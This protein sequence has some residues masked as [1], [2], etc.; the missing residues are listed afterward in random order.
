MSY[1]VETGQM[2]YYIHGDLGLAV[3]SALGIE[4]LPTEGIAFLE[5]I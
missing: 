1:A 3:N 4:D 2:G 5:Y